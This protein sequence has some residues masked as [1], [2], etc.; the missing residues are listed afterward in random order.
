MTT[1]RKTKPKKR[2][3]RTKKGLEF[4]DRAEVWYWRLRSRNG[5]IVADG[6]EGYSSEA[7]A[8]QGFRAAANLA[9]KALSEMERK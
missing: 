5:R 3:A 7:K 8:R 9:A 4:F 2:S 6:S 1:A